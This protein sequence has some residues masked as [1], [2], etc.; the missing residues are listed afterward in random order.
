M[1][2]RR[3]AIATVLCGAVAGA[4]AVSEADAQPLPNPSSASPIDLTWNAP[5]GCSDSATI[6]KQVVSLRGNR[7]GSAEHLVA[8]ADV[9]LDPSGVWNLKI[10]TTFADG[11]HGE[12]EIQA[13]SCKAAADAT[14]SILALALTNRAQE[15]ATAPLV[16]ADAG[17]PITTTTPATSATTSTTADAAA[18]PPVATVATQPDAGAPPPDVK[19]SEP[20]E[21]SR[22]HIPLRPYVGAFFGGTSGDLPSL[23]L[24]GGGAL[25]LMY[26]MARLEGYGEYFAFGRARFASSAGGANFQVFSAGARTCLS[27]GD[28]FSLGPCAA[29]ELGSMRGQSFDVSKPSSGN[30]LVADGFLGALG[31]FPLDK[32][33]HFALRA[34][35]EIGASFQRPQFVLDGVGFV[36]QPSAI[37]GRG[38]VGAELRF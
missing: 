29:F 6:L 28:T 8:T 32:N 23:G 10:V 35:L 33:R 13:E 22:A 2:S 9:A 21:A 24:G 31:L 37:T 15:M 38:T 20:P 30:A 17:A 19:P 25:G 36:H 3:L 16:I 11:T 27:F 12:R 34:L 1:R 5:A 7:T 14:A 18:P 4:L 26:G